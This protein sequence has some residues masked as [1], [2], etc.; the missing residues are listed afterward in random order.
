MI[1]QKL[2]SHVIVAIIL[3]IIFDYN[4]LHNLYFIL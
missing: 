2:N 4:I 1:T 3:V